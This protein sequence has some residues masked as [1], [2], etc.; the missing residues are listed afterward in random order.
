MRWPFQP[1]GASLVLAGHDHH[2]ERLVR[3]NL[4]FCVNGLG[5]RSQYNMSISPIAGSQFR[6]NDNYGAQ[7]FEASAD[8]LSL[9]FYARTGEL[10]DG[11]TLRK[12]LSLVPA[13]EGVFP[14]PVLETARVAFSLPRRTDVKLVVL[15]VAGHEVALLLD[16]PKGAGHHEVQWE[17][18]SLRP[19]T[20]FLQLRTG[21]YAPVLRTVVL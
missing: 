14:T 16:G 10:V 13:L 21:R 1:W 17:R 19:G 15:D 3:G 11:F 6:Y 4:M 9:R 7:L 5:G 18:G 2:Y 20:Y 8:S 12:S